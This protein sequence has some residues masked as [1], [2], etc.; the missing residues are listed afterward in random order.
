MA[1]VPD[2]GNDFSSPWGKWHSKFIFLRKI[3]NTWV[4]CRRVHRRMN[5][6]ALIENKPCYDYALNDFELMSKMEK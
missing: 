5:Y 4:F 1:S 3:N 6:Y 2:G